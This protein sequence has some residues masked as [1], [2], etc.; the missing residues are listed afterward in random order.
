MSFNGV[1]KTYVC[2]IGFQ[3]K[4]LCLMKFSGAPDHCLNSLTVCK[5]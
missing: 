1:I 5:V 3:G 4:R 2:N